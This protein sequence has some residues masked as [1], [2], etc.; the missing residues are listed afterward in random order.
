MDDVLSDLQKSSVSVEVALSDLFDL[1]LE[2]NSKDN[3][4]VVLVLFKN[5]PQL[6]W[7]DK[8]ICR[9]D[10]ELIDKRIQQKQEEKAKGIEKEI[11]F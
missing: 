7:M 6:Y 5:A 10:E 11:V 8:V 1:C 2:R 3:M 4:T 9:P